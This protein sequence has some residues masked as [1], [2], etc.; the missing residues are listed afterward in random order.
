MRRTFDLI[1]CDI[2][3][4]KGFKK[5][6][7]NKEF[8]SLSLNYSKIFGS[9]FVHFSANLECFVVL[10]LFNS[11]FSVVPEDSVNFQVAAVVFKIV[12]VVFQSTLN[13]FDN[14]RV[15]ASFW[16]VFQTELTLMI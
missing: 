3:R 5:R 4:K 13:L 7:K 9:F 16:T 10:E 8:K 1:E 15:L 14:C 6:E 12:S 11:H 2:A